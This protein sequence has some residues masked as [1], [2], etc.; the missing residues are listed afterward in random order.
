MRSSKVS[1]TN[2][3]VQARAVGFRDLAGRDDKEL[4]EEMWRR[5][6][7]ASNHACGDIEDAHLFERISKLVFNCFQGLSFV[8]PYKMQFEK[9]ILSLARWQ[10]EA[11][12]LIDNATA[13]ATRKVLR[14]ERY[15]SDWEWIL[16]R[17]KEIENTQWGDVN[18]QNQLEDFIATKRKH[19]LRMQQIADFMQARGR[20]NLSVSP[21]GKHAITS[22]PK[23]SGRREYPLPIKVLAVHCDRAL[24]KRVY[25]HAERTRCLLER[26][27]LYKQG[28]QS[29]PEAFRGTLKRWRRDVDEAETN[30]NRLR[31]R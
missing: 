24:C 22:P 9:D 21:D 8:W 14:F 12:G 15:R 31:S 10:M 4:L 17:M 30:T 2:S 3:K 23:R 26:L 18:A 20:G 5:S 13:P 29:K 28:A 27:N 1:R 6:R 16:A 7:E 25:D 19:L 11:Y